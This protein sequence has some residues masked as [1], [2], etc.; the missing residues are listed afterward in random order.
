GLLSI[1]T[2]LVGISATIPL[3][4][5]ATAS[6]RQRVGDSW[7][8]MG[9][10][11]WTNWS[12]LGVVPITPNTTLVPPGIPTALGFNWRDG[13]LV[14]VGAEYQFRPNMILRAGVGFERSPIDDS[15]RSV[16]LPDND[17]IWLSAGATYHWNTQLSIDIAYSHLFMDDGAINIVPGNPAFVPALGT[18][19]GT[20]DGQVDIFSVALRYKF[21]P[22]PPAAPLITKG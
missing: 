3:P 7:T 14:S 13:W 5:V 12:R 15:N 4:D 2:A 9:T 10:V 22:P 11:E 21:L 16:R 18:F 19:T 17:R 8:L 6:I 1:P 20:S